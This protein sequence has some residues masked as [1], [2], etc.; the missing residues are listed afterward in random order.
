LNSLTLQ[1]GQEKYNLNIYNYNEVDDFFIQLDLAYSTLSNP[2]YSNLIPTSFVVFPVS[3]T[4]FTYNFTLINTLESDQEFRVQFCNFTK[5]LNEP[6]TLNMNSDC[7]TKQVQFPSSNKIEHRYLKNVDEGI[8]MYIVD[9]TLV[10]E[11]QISLVGDISLL[12]AYKHVSIC[13]PDSEKS[14]KKYKE[15]LFF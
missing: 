9:D 7:Y 4:D 2:E 12:N 15:Y 8:F 14:I 13:D 1:N 3:D 10:Y 11:Y 6:K 5:H